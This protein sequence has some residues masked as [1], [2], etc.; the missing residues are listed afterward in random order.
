MKKIFDQEQPKSSLAQ[1]LN[2]AFAGCDT[3][4]IA[5]PKRR[6]VSFSTPKRPRLNP[7]ADRYY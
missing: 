1:S 3:W 5:P 4:T 7:A 6:A 2:A